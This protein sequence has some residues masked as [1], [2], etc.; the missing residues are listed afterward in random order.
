MDKALILAYKVQRKIRR[1]LRTRC[2][3]ALTVWDE[4]SLNAALR[5]KSA[6]ALLLDFADL[7]WSHWPKQWQ[8]WLSQEEADAVIEKAEQ[9][10]TNQFDLLGSGLKD[11]GEFIDWHSDIR[12]G[13]RWPSDA[14]HRKIAWDAVPPGTDIKM[15]WELSRCQH[16]VTMGLAEQVA[17]NGVYY[18]AFKQ[19]VRSWI[20][21]NQ[22]GFGVNW[23]CAMDVA[24]RS[25][26]WLTALSLFKDNLKSDTDEAFADELVE[27]L[28]L[29]G[30]HIMRNLEWQGPHSSSLAN[31]FL[32]DISGLLVIGVLFRNTSQGKKWLRFAHHWFENEVR[33]QVF[34]DGALFETSTSYHRLTYEMFLWASTMAENIEQPFSDGY[35]ERLI[36]MASFV[37]AYTTP[38]GH[39]VQFG[40]NDGGR[41]LTA[42]IENPSD[43]RYLMRDASSF[44]A[45]SNSLLLGGGKPLPVGNDTGTFDQGGYYFAQNEEAW[46]GVRAGEVSHAGAH[47]HADQLSFV[48]TLGESDIVVDPGTGV[49]SADT[50]KRNLY[51]S[52][53]A[54]NT[55]RL[56]RL[57]ANHFDGGMSGLFRMRDDTRTEVE[58]WESTA[59]QT[60]FKGKHYGYSREREGCVCEREILLNHN[61]LTVNDSLSNVREGDVLEWTLCFSPNVSVAD[62][63][64][65]LW[66]TAGG[67]RI[68]VIFPPGA[69][70]EVRRGQMSP[71]YGVELNTNLLDIKYLVNKDGHYH[72]ELVLEWN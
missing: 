19:Q 7:S 64:N 55:P 11:L 6:K 49:Y 5:G 16:F 43:H 70:W 14:H 8:Q 13:Y 48:L 61:R 33:R 51:R 47:A 30:R 42:G 28:W 3:P 60:H 65:D 41:F 2:T 21:S 62:G 56:N 27:S 12:T 26:N 53:A 66:L 72:Q 38:S 25:V 18:E 59:D 63:V 36:G 58:T 17:G 9:A 67:K 32:A 54:H 37:S 34:E 22:C 57:E 10:R 4:R 1:E 35:Q 71:T 50:E 29:H 24:I 46:I 45:K 44:G 15:P 39:A 52:S 69:A 20:K 40:D 23:V 31:H 68:K